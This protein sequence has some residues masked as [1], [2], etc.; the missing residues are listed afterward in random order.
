MALEPIFFASQAELRAWFEAHHQ[1]AAELLVG[2][3]KTATK[4]P[5]ITWAQSVD[6]ALCFGWIDGIRKGRDED[7]YTIRFTPRKPRSNWSAVNI[8]RVHEL[9]ELGLMK[10]AGLKAFEG[11]D[12]EKANQYSYERKQGQL[13]AEREAKFKTHPAA[14]EFFQ[15]QAPSYQRAAIWWVISAKKDETRASRL[16]TLIEHSAEKKRIP[17]LTSPTK[18]KKDAAK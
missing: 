16:T 9:T 1:D 11:R 6:E 17:M 5:S 10:P 8:K 3:Y 2:Y 4:R 13:D 12:E 18:Q 15:S 7:S 14:W